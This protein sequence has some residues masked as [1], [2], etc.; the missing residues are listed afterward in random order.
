MIEKEVL[1]RIDRL[2]MRRE[3][4]VKIYGV[5]RLPDGSEVQKQIKGSPAEAG[6]VDVII[7]VKE[8]GWY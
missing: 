3:E 7:S 8:G 4:P 6:L 5:Y 1:K 2:Q